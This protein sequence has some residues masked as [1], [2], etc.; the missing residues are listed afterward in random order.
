[1]ATIQSRLIHLKVTLPCDISFLGEKSAS[2]EVFLME[3]CLP[4]IEELLNKLYYTIF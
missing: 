3:S 1:M 4:I 2:Q